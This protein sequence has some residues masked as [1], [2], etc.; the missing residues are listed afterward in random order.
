MLLDRRDAVGRA[1]Q[2]DSVVLTATPETCTV[3]LLWDRGS[4]TWLVRAEGLYSGLDIAT[5]DLLW[6]QAL[7]QLVARGARV[8]TAAEMQLLRTSADVGDLKR[9]QRDL[10]IDLV[11]ARRW[12]RK[13]G[14]PQAAKQLRKFLRSQTRGQPNDDVSGHA[15]AARQTGSR[16]MSGRP[17]TR[18]EAFGGAV[19]STQ[20]ELECRYGRHMH[21]LGSASRCLSTELC[22]SAKELIPEA[23]IYSCGTS[24]CLACMLNRVTCFSQGRARQELLLGQRNTDGGAIDLRSPHHLGPGIRLGCGPGLVHAR[25]PRCRPLGDDPRRGKSAVG[26]AWRPSAY[27]CREAAPLFTSSR[28]LQPARSTGYRHRRSMSVVAQRQP[29][30]RCQ[31]AFRAPAASSRQQQ[32]AGTTRRGAACR[33]GGGFSPAVAAITTAPHRQT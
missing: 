33:T 8:G 29:A 20:Q 16:G 10:V 19:A 23:V 30:R 18:S 2:L 14:E 25:W 11:A 28:A 26:A 4:D 17:A 32:T 7:K 12:L 24:C 1:Y 5:S 22:A 13:A 9:D 27:R 6:P 31:A 15:R 3:P 21:P